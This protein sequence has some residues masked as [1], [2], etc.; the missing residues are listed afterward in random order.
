MTDTQPDIPAD[1]RVRRLLVYRLGS[2]GD[3]VVA[4]P[5]LRLVAR[6]FPSAERRLLTNLPVSEKVTPASAVLEGTSLIHGYLAYPSSTRRLS[7]LLRIWWQIVRWRPQVLVYMAGARGLSS[8]R[9]DRLFF[10]LCGIR[11][12]IGVPLTQSMQEHLPGPTSIGPEAAIVEREAFRIARNLAELGDARLEVPASWDL[13]L[14]PAEFAAADRSIAD[15]LH[16]SLSLPAALPILAVSTG[17]KLQSKDWG[18][19][20]WRA[21]LSC[22]ATRW[23]GHTLLMIGAAQERD[24]SA[25][26]AEGWQSSGGGPVANL[27][28]CLTPRQSAAAIARASLFLGHDSG[29]MHLAAS[30]GVPIV[31]VFSARDLPGRWWPYGERH[32]LLYHPVSCRGCILD[33]CIV[34]QKRCLTSITVEEVLQAVASLWPPAI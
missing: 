14:T 31:A 16:P 20:N 22:I 26:A 8:A 11:R 23:P 18:I 4:L 19:D 9:R 32:R 2:L 7:D 33:T 3:I 12:Q 10:R 24:A 21:L 15:E 30:V 17:T 27:C 29:P 6:A 1:N 28:G 34:E 13:C 5:S 25:L